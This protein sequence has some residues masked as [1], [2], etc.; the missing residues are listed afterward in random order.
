MLPPL[1]LPFR[2]ASSCL[3]MPCACV[4]RRDFPFTLANPKDQDSVSRQVSLISL[5]MLG[6][7]GQGAFCPRPASFPSLASSRRPA[8]A[9]RYL[10]PRTFPTHHLVTSQSMCTCVRVCSIPK[11]NTSHH[12][13]K[14]ASQY[15]DFRY[16]TGTFP[17][18]EPLTN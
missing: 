9:L 13:N 15:R 10:L 8:V 4:Y 14:A 17:F 6:R 2:L 11:I 7:V 16:H 18:D 3:Y 12:K 1:R 5:R